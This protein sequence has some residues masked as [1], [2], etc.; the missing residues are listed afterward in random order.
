MEFD[1]AQVKRSK[2]HIALNIRIVRAQTNHSKTAD[3][4]EAV[5][6][7]NGDGVKY[8]GFV[9]SL[10]DTFG[11]IETMA[12]DKEIFFHYRYGIIIV[13]SIEFCCPVVG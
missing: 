2:D 7:E 6:S 5:R 13:L 12:H 8:K 11:F 10:K 9:A 4:G 3:N 1:L